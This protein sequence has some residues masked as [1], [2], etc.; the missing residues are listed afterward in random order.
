MDERHWPF[1][2]RK[3]P[4]TLTLPK[5]SLWYNLEV[6]ATRFPDRA[7][8]LFYEG[9]V[10]YAEFRQQAEWL[11]GFLQRECGVKRGDRVALFLQNCPQFVIAYYA[12][13]RADAVVVP[14]NC[15]NLTAELEHILRDSGAT[16][17][18]TAQDLF[19]RVEP[20]LGNAI[21][22]A[23]VACYADYI[24][25]APQETPPES[26][27]APRLSFSATEVTLWSDALARRIAPAAHESTAEDLCVLAYTSGSTGRPKGCVHRHR[28]VLHTAIATTHWNDGRQDA[29]TLSVLPLFHVTGM[30]NGMNAPIYA[31]ATIVLLPRW[32]RDVAASLI[33]RYG[34]TNLT[35]VP[36]MAVD[37]IS[38]PDVDGYDLSSLRVFGGG[39][40]AMP[41]AVAKKLKE[42]CGLTYLE[43][44]GL[45]E[46]LAPSHANP[47]DRPK[48][49]CL[50]IPIFNTEARVIDPETLAEVPRGAVGEIVVHG[51]QV[52][53]EYWNNPAENAAAFITLDG[54]R[55]LRTGDLG[56]VDEEGY[57]FFV[58]R[59]KRM[60]N[61]AGFKVWPAEVESLLYAHPAVQEAC[62]IATADERS[63]ERVKAVI[64]PKAAMRA[65]VTAEQIT[66]WAR[67]H[68]SAYKVPR[69]VEFV[70]ALPRSASGK[71]DW[72]LL[73][74]RERS[75]H[76]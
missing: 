51:P 4:R 57:Y 50:G 26:I 13:L 3:L 73:Q 41:E 14:I 27:S 2:P 76:S 75:K 45:T 56:R 30:Q 40:A 68:M 72:R 36:A 7:A 22:H 44:Y 31:G 59:L 9:L 38:S 53:D 8:L 29:C 71:I 35:L 16:V 25:R 37:L 5:T 32:N 70:D 66:A 46:T 6:S 52:L 65:T 67:D 28:G 48:T 43:G 11:A 17:V 33:R 12:I 34:V 42:K 1:F 49:Q 18:V 15:M 69:D 74:E 21:R 61:A 58:D 19:P 60:I 62:V 23:V 54:K 47:G 24:G 63:G 20:L 10:T 55:F 64:V 39:G